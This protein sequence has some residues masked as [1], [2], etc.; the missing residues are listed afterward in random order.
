MS[1][2]MAKNPTGG[3]TP[4]HVMERHSL[5]STSVVSVV[6]DFLS[7][8]LRAFTIKEKGVN[9]QAVSMTPNL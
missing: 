7:N 9:Y 1:L 6:L 8:P 5:D 3:V 4:Q 2:R